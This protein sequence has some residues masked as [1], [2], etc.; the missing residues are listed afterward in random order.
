MNTQIILICSAGMSTSLLVK[1]MKDSAKAF[2]ETISVEAYAESA[3]S[4]E[5]I[6][7]TEVILLAPQISYKL[8]DFQKKYEPLGKKVAVINSSDYGMLNGENVLKTAMAL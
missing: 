3:V 4:Q 7:A 1:K 5:Q 8:K 2:P 6:D